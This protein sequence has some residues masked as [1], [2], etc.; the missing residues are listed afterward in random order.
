MS[1][2]APTRRKHWRFISLLSL[3]ALGICATIALVGNHYRIKPFQPALVY[4][5]FK[6]YATNA[7]GE[8]CLTYRVQNNNRENILGLAEFKGSKPGSGLFVNLPTSQ[9]QTFTIQPPPGSSQ[10]QLSI[11]CFV[12]DRG[13]FAQLYNLT[14]R[15]KGKSPARDISKL[16]FSVPAPVVEP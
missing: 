12:K 8:R 15:I 2:G 14:E 7:A 1:A 4:I 10:Y 13:I 16:L 11:T 5:S 9:S 6:G 3:A